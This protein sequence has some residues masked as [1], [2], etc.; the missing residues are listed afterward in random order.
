[1]DVSAAA[2]S[3]DRA[4]LQT[5]DAVVT[6]LRLRPGD[7]VRLISPASPPN[8]VGVAE[9]RS[10][11]ESWGLRVDLG[12]NVF[13]RYG[14]LAGTDEQ[15][16]ADFNAALRD[17]EVRA[18][19]ATRGGKG[20]YRIADRL[21]F[22]A[23]RADPKFFVGISDNT[24]LHLSLFRHCR[25][26]GLHGALYADP[27]SGRVSNTTISALRGALTGTWNTIA[28]GPTSRRRS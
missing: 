3:P 26:V 24:A 15:R 22:W 17:P 13:T 27:V 2:V 16:L 10:V 25:Q 28:S 6:P 19:V 21:D 12:E 4:M 14:Y 23:A 7:L 5:M 11:L 8:E 20:S 1:M 18:I 9:A